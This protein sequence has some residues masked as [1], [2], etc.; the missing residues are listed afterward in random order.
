MVLGFL[1]LGVMGRPM[2]ANLVAAGHELV[3]WTRSGVPLEGA[4]FAPSPAGVFTASEVVFLMLAGPEAIDGV[5]GPHVA[6]R[7]VVHMGT[8]SPDYSADLAGRIVAAGG[9]YV[10]APVSGS[11]GP[12]EA[13]QLVA[14]LAGQDQD[15]SRVRPL[16]PPMCRQV[17]DCGPVPNGL[18][19]KLAVNTYLIGMVTALAEA[20]HFAERH[21]L[22]LDVLRQV[23]DAGP[24]ASYVSRGKAGKIVDGDYAVQASIRDVHYNNRL[25]VE[26]AAARGIASPLLDVCRRLF[27]EAEELGHGGLDMAAVIHALTARTVR[28]AAAD[29]GSASSPAAAGSAAAAAP[30]S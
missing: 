19:M 26:A 18:R 7:T 23:L 4:R 14:M 24:M 27:A 17:I 21:D 3:V 1:G 9:R 6:G 2:A 22:D 28:D 25:I 13:G 8:T 30:P 15:L 12:A 20:F 10:E 16:L 29:T 11:R 5:I